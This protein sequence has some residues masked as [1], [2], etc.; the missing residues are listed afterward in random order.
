M[1]RARRVSG[2]VVFGSPPGCCASCVHGLVDRELQPYLQR[3]AVKRLSDQHFEVCWQHAKALMMVGPTVPQGY[4]KLR[5]LQSQS[6]FTLRQLDPVAKLFDPTLDHAG[7]CIRCAGS[8]ARP[9]SI[10]SR[11]TLVL[12]VANGNDRTLLDSGEP[13]PERV[14]GQAVSDSDVCLCPDR[15]C[16]RQLQCRVQVCC[17]ER[18]VAIIPS[19]CTCGHWRGE[20]LVQLK[21]QRISCDLSRR[22]WWEHRHTEITHDNKVFDGYQFVTLMCPPSLK[23]TH[24]AAS[25]ALTTSDRAWSAV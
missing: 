16:H 22:W 2:P 7:R 1:P 12:H 13:G 8:W 3:R 24:P 17:P 15:A 9:G 6:D 25:I 18:L 20:G 5:G 19:S 14:D 4:E 11:R 23:G 21:R 10:F